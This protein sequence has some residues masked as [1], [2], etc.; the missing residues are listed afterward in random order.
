MEE[1]NGFPEIYL[2][3]SCKKYKHQDTCNI[4][5]QDLTINSGLLGIYLAVHIHD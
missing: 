4:H 2:I 3:T 1:N 5:L